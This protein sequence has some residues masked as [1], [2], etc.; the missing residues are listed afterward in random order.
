MANLGQKKKS[1][2]ALMRTRHRPLEVAA[3]AALN[4]LSWLPEVTSTFLRL[5][6]PSWERFPLLPP[7]SSLILILSWDH[8]HS[9]LEVTPISLRLLPPTWGCYHLSL[10]STLLTN[11]GL[12]WRFRHLLMANTP[13]YFRI[14]LPP[15][16]LGPV[17]PWGLRC[18]K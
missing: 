4:L 6:P 9:L 10:R 17:L 15:L 3:N 1:A 18:L 2:V 12:H 5:L 7:W 14:S 16:W 13:A 11:W 8:R